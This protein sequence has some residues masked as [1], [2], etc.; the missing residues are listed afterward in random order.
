MNLVIEVDPI[1]AWA[2]IAAAMARVTP[3][4][5]SKPCFT[6]KSSLH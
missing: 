2:G 3:A 6:L 5:V 1:C 4:R